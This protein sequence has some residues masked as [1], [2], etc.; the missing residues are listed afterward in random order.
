M[1]PCHRLGAR[2]ALILALTGAGVAQQYSFRRYGAAEGLRNMVVLSFAQDRAGYIWAGSEGGLYRYD[3]TRFRRMG[4]PKG[5]PALPGFTP[6]TWPPMGPSGAHACNQILRF[7]GRIFHEVLGP[8]WPPQ[9]RTPGQ[10]APRVRDAQDMPGPA[11][12]IGL[13]GCLCGRRPLSSMMGE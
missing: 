10:H 3:G 8:Q 4:R 7:D 2:A 1:C 5:C 6:S 11:G 12:L 9:R 13:A